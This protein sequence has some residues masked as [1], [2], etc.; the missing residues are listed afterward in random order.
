MSRQLF[1]CSKV[2]DDMIVGIINNNLYHKGHKPTTRGKLL[3]D[4]K[5]IELINPIER[6]ERFAENQNKETLH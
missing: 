6:R 5:V 1:L 4:G 3:K 2:F